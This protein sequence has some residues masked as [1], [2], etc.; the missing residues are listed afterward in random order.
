MSS[1]DLPALF[2]AGTDAHASQEGW[3]IFG[4]PLYPMYNSVVVDCFLLESKWAAMYA[5]MS[6]LR[7]SCRTQRT[8]RRWLG[9]EL[10]LCRSNPRTFR[11]SL[12]RCTL[13][14]I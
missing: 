6:D 8:C 10:K 5:G 3:H 2:W 7:F 12:G 4:T 11:I 14:I 13:W 1:R 9:G